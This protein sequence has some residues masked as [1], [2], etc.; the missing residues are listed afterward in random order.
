MRRRQ[1]LQNLV[2]GAS[3]GGL[4]GCGRRLAPRGAERR[5]RVI[6]LAF[7]GM[8]PK[9][10]RGLMMAGKVPNFSRLAESGTF[11]TVTT[12]DPPQTP[13]AF[14]NIISG[15]DPGTHQIFDFIHRDPQAKG[16]IPVQPFFST[17]HVAAS[18]SPR[19]LSLGKWRIPLGGSASP[20]LLRRGPAYW[21]PLVKQGTE[22]AVFFLPSNYPPQDAPGPG[23]LTCVSGMGTPDLLGGLGEFTLVTPDAPL[24]GKKVTGGKY[25]YAELEA[26]SHRAELSI[27]GPENFLIDPKKTDGKIPRMEVPYVL[28]RDPE[29][30]LVKIEIEDRTI[31]LKRGEWSEWV[32]LN[33]PTAIPGSAALETIRA[34][35]SL[36]GMVRFYVKKVHPKCEIYITP[37]NID[38]LRPVNQFSQ[39]AELSEKLARGHGRYYTLGIPEDYNALQ[40]GA[41]NED[42]FLSQAYLAHSERE[43]MYRRAL[44]EFKSGCLF[45]YF[46]T[47]DLVSHMFWRERDPEHPGW[48]PE[49]GGRYAHVIDDLYVHV[50]GLLGETL[51]TLRD[52]DTLLVLSDHGFTSF[53]RSVNLNRLLYEQGYLVLKKG[54]KSTSVRFFAGVDWAKTR[55]YALGLNSVFVNLRGREREGIVAAG[56]EQQLLVD[57]LAQLLLD[58]RDDEQDGASPIKTVIK[59]AEQFPKADPHIAPDLIVGYNHHYRIGWEAPLGGIA[60]TPLA[61]N[62]EPWSGD[63]CVASELVPGMLMCNRPLHSQR[64]DL[65]D[66]GPTLLELCGAALPG[67]MSGR[68]MIHVS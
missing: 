65:T 43:E 21:Q 4:L 24:R 22:A 63:H 41:L 68:P 53:R 60:K 52:D 56:R 19:G 30:D 15:C 32:A 34:Q 33:F 29:R 62:L 47:T 59:V 9:L 6:V 23:K 61:D 11:T 54:V 2:S 14:S 18:E 25:V 50:D 20:E 38:P 55:A 64:P 66:V 48:D 67:E 31:L 12:S 1:F 58:L 13:V 39:P 46:G 45:Y 10:L 42:E 36:P 26:S 5:G 7:D 16:S 35:V 8:E 27:E 51:D 57:K 3:V 44:A 37:V 49:K 17:S 28:T 40:Q